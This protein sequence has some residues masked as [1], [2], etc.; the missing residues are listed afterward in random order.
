MLIKENMMNQNLQL[1]GPDAPIGH[2]KN[3]G[4]FG[5]KWQESPG[6]GAV[7][8]C[9][10][11]VMNAPT[12][13]LHPHR[14]ISAVAILFED[15]VGQMYSADSVGTNH[16]FGAG[17]VHWTLAGN[18][19]EHTQTPEDDANIHAVQMFIDLPQWLR[20]IP[21]MTFHLLA[22][23]VPIYKTAACRIRVLVGS[24]FGLTSP[25]KIPQDILILE[26]WTESDF[27]IPVPQGWRLWLY[28]RSDERAG[29]SSQPIVRGQFLAVA[30]P[31][32][33]IF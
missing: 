2:G 23:D 21:A 32:S 31:T 9:D 20:F 25:L 1:R 7:L 16:R 4:F 22:K 5:N 15:T 18:G 28:D 12:F 26:G 11:Y 10:S 30:S 29:Y 6:Q 19:V 3:S 33:V 27:K 8:M 17:D 14:N 13:P 24:A